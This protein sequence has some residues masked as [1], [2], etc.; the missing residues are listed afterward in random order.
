MENSIIND[1][2]LEVINCTTDLV[3][4]LQISEATGKCHNNIRAAIIRD[5]NKINFIRRRD[6]ALTKRYVI[7][8]IMNFYN[9]KVFIS[10]YSEYRP[11]VALCTSINDL[12]SRLSKGVSEDKESDLS[13]LISSIDIAEI[14][15]KPHCLVIDTI[16]SKKNKITYKTGLNK[17]QE[18]GKVM[19]A[20]LNLSQFKDLCFTFHD[21]RNMSIKAGSI[22][23]LSDMILFADNQDQ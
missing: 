22:Q 21:Y 2:D 12:L 10:R 23:E 5:S 1:N 3:S 4:S 17:S 9:F 16:R 11:A 13:E 14:M 7:S 20:L 8:H 19:C 6:Q 18:G 15:S